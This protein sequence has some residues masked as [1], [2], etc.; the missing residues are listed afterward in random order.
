MGGQGS[1]GKRHLRCHGLFYNRPL[2]NGGGLQ[3]FRS[4]LEIELCDQKPNGRTLLTWYMNP[5]GSEPADPTHIS[6]IPLIT[7]S[8]QIV[9]EAVWLSTIP[10]ATQAQTVLMMDLLNCSRALVLNLSD[11]CTPDSN[12]VGACLARIANNSESWDSVLHDQR[13]AELECVLHAWSY[14]AV[15]G[16]WGVLTKQACLREAAQQV[17]A[18]TP[19]IIGAPSRRKWRF[20][21]PRP[22]AAGGPKWRY[23][24]AWRKDVASEL[25]LSPEHQAIAQIKRS[26]DLLVDKNFIWQRSKNGQ[27]TIDL[28]LAPLLTTT[29]ASAGKAKKSGRSMKQDPLKE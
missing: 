23:Y 16:G 2:L 7:Q 6:Q 12:Q 15:I 22:T 11:I 25:K 29:P 28:S 3:R 19:D 8:S 20:R 24:G 13:R 1:T 17:F 10:D 27:I 14:V 18:H 9:Q 26:V 4:Q 5:G 21:H